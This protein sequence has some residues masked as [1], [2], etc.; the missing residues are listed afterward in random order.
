MIFSNKKA[1]TYDKFDEHRKNLQKSV[2]KYFGQYSRIYNFDQPFWTIPE[3]PSD[4]P[5]EDE[6][7]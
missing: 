2:I 4:L 6:L 5:N 1:I 7:F 3:L